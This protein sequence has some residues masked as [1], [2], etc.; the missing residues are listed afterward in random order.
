[1]PSSPPL[2]QPLSTL[3]M[4]QPLLCLATRPSQQTATVNAA[5]P[6]SQFQNTLLMTSM[7]M[8]ESPTGQQIQARAFL[9]SGSTLSLI[10]NRIVQQLE[11]RKRIDKL[12]RTG[13][14]DLT[15][16][17]SHSTTVLVKTVDTNQHC[18]TLTAHI[19]PMVTCDLP[20]QQAPRVRQLPHIRGL[21]LADPRFDHPGNIDLLIGGD[22][23]G[24]LILSKPLEATDSDIVAFET[25]FGWAIMG[26]YSLQPSS[27]STTST[28]NMCQ[29]RRLA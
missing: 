13:V 28:A 23:L 21:K 3:L 6:A 24:K 4:P 1:M 19:L 9:D 16:N 2:I 29:Y 20:L 27:S 25:V 17:S 11:L 7:V 14:C 22:R 15:T 10:S 12:S 18:L 8:L 26:P 5:L